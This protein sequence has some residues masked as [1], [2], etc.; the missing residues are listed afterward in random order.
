MILQSGLYPKST[1]RLFLGFKK[2]GRCFFT[3]KQAN[4]PSYNYSF[5]VVQNDTFGKY[6][7]E[8]IVMKMKYNNNIE[9]FL[10]SISREISYVEIY[11][12]KNDKI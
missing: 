10:F 2:N 7:S 3:N 12:F 8:N 9:E 6:E 5:E 4:T 11:D 1:K